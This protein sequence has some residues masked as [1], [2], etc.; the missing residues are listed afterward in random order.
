MR[1]LLLICSLLLLMAARG[2]AQS[3]VITGTVT[4]KAN[5]PLEAVTVAVVETQNAVSTDK[6]GK[7]SLQALDGQTIRFTYIGAKPYTVTVNAS[8]LKLNVQL[9]LENTA[10]NEV[11]VTG[12]TSERKKDLT[13]AVTVVN[14][15]DIK[16]I[17]EGNAIKALQGRVPGLTILSDGSPNGSVTVRLRGTTTLG[18]ND[19]LYVIDGIPSTRGLQEIN[20][21]DIE[22]I[23]VLRDAS[24]ASIYGTR[25][26]AG[27]IIVTTKRGKKGMQRIDFDASSSLQYY[28]SKLTP[29]NTQQHGAAYWR[30]AVNDGADPNNNGIYTYNWNKNFTNPVLNNVIIPEYIDAA[31][32]MKAANTNWFNEV[33][34]SSLLQSYNLS[35]SNGS[36]KGSSFF[37]LGYFDNKGIIKESRDTKY[38][39]RFN[40][41]YNL[42]N[43]KLKIGENISATY[44]RDPILP[45]SS[46]TILSIIENPIIPV[47]TVTGGWGGPVAGMDDRDNPVRLI[48]DNKQNVNAF[49]RV[50]GNAF[51]D[52]TIL[53]TLHFRTTFSADFAG[54]YFRSLQLPYV[55]G[56]LSNPANMVGQSSDYAVTLRWQNQLTY[57]LTYGKNKINV[58]LGEE[59]IKD[60]YQ[61]FN[62]SA[63]GL[64]LSNYDYAYLSAGTTNI[65]ANGAG[66]NDALLSYFGKVN[67][68]YN[69]KYLASVTVRRDGSSKFGSNNRYAVFPA[70]SLGWRISQEDFIKSLPFISDLKVRYGWGKTGNQT[71][72]NNANYSL[73]Q[74][75][76]GNAQPFSGDSGSAYD[77][78]GKGSGTL[79][80]GFT[81]IQTGNTSV[82]WE[83]TTQSNY[84]LDFGL[85]NN[86]LTGSFDYFLKNTTNILYAP[87]YIAVLGE[88]G[89]ETFN[90]ASMKNKGF[91]VLLSYNSTITK[92]IS[93][94]VT[95][96]IASYRNKVTYLP[97]NVLTGYPGNGTTQTI[98]GRSINS[99][100]GYVA[101]GL[102]TTQAEVNNS[103]TQPGKGL[104]RIRYADLNNDGVID[105]QDRKFLGTSDPN[106]TYG[107]NTAIG[108]KDITLTF[109]FQGVQGGLVYNNYKYLTDFTSLAP[110]SNWGNRVLNAWTP[111]NPNSTIPALTL[112]DR[113][114]EG[115]YS[116]Y[117]LESGSYL[118][119]RNIQ[120][121]YDLKNAFKKI[122]LQRATVY[123][124][125]SNLLRFKSSSYTA[126]DPENPANAY[127][128]PVITTVGV[129]FSY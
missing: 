30:A 101:Q 112:V 67:Y 115:R 29:L 13:G 35:I 129:N 80:S 24:S 93:L 97:E 53:P 20:Q 27:V 111:Q 42:F 66:S 38:T 73:Y 75:I 98:L 43:G 86:K 21:S 4:D 125:A 68:A 117:F 114:N 11:V 12:Y 92:D 25:A 47:H 34:Q 127:P 7:F 54:N 77:I 2:Y 95:G 50:F 88:G 56:F 105:D 113:N 6:K 58:L 44:M 10:L 63:Q 109:F 22:S 45:T 8:T 81:S 79:P 107:L 69:N 52:L 122:K 78:G 1:K 16:D 89:N 9:D 108:Y 94:N 110:G 41:D 48:H 55:A 19:P 85:F 49:G 3:R 84:G 60:K 72:P 17:P 104:G 18:N 23:Q 57:D 82:K 102:F 90:G 64:A 32:T 65:L 116:S 74:S 128:I 124:Q 37:S 119:L 31:H 76:Y 14:V 123:I 71:I 61:N 39:A 99:E 33:S 106:F 103:A 96:N 87:P 100:F 126:P 36:E 51:A 46:I 91:E 70:A 40:S 121:A 83:T 62:A 118:K 15:N 5:N 120:L 26:A 59:N 28:T